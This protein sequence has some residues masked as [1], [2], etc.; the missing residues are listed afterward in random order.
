MK[1]YNISTR[2]LNNY[3]YV[4]AILL[5]AGIA[6]LTG[7]KSEDERSPVITE[8]TDLVLVEGGQARMVIVTADSPNPIVNLSVA[9]LVEH[10]KLATGVEL[11]TTTESDAPAAG[12]KVRLFLGETEAAAELGIDIAAMENDAF[13]FRTVGND[14]YILGRENNREYQPGSMCNGTL[15]GSYELIER[16]LGV[17]WLWPGDLGRHVP[18]VNRVA[19]ASADEVVPPAL[20]GRYYWLGH[21]YNRGGVVSGYYYGKLDE[22]KKSTLPDYRPE[23]RRLAFSADGLKN[24]YLDTLIFLRR[25]RMGFSEPRTLMS[26]THIFQGWWDSYGK[27]HPE[28]FMM[29]EAGERV[30]PTLCVSN[31][32]LA[33]FIVESEKTVW[34]AGGIKNFTLGEVDERVYCHCPECMA[35]DEPLPEG[36]PTEGSNRVISN[37][38]A[39]FAQVIRDLVRERHP[40]TDFRVTPFVYFNYFHKPTVDLDLTG[41]QGVFCPWFSGFDPYYPKPEEEHQRLI[42]TWSGWRQTGMDLCYRP[43]YLLMGYVMPHLS[44][45]Q[46]GEM[47]R[48]A[49]AKGNKSVEFDSLCAHWAVKGPMYYVHMRLTTDPTLEVTDI[50]REYFDSFGPAAA[51]VEAY[52]DYWEAYSANEAKRGGVSWMSPDQAR[53]LYPESSF[54]AA[55]V[56]LNEAQRMATADA[57]PVYGERVKFLDIGLRHAELAAAFIGTLRGGNRAPTHDPAQFA[58]A[59]QALRDL[60]AFRRE[61]EQW[62][63]ADLIAAATTENKGLQIDELFDED[64]VVQAGSV[65]RFEQPWEHWFFRRD[66]ENRGTEGEWFRSDVRASGIQNFDDG[67]GQAFNFDPAQWTRVRVPSRLGNTDIGEYLGYGWYATTFVAPEG[68]AGKPA[69]LYFEGVDEQAWIYINGRYIGEHTVASEGKPVGELWDRPFEINVPAGVIHGKGRNLL[70]VRT[71]NSAGAAG[72]WREVSLGTCKTADK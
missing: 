18:A 42:D 12:E 55:R 59:R 35:W 22:L 37:R 30:G 7:C 56:F 28:W 52:F 21:Y 33:R 57:N 53:L 24:Y 45:W 72:I 48:H 49:A 23:I 47:F 19:I 62:Y 50:R 41:T 29:N 67:G 69:T 3:N 44:T 64:F 38:Y 71:H 17:R 11:Q 54:A 25:H 68:M 58:A 65:V 14:L 6:F 8:S 34:E 31:P 63:F 61:H 20:K 46:T 13:I 66:L 10:V 32:E 27:E 1:N 9:E 26:T 15:Y 60:L 36:W 4:L 5:I 40:G 51:A 2:Q 70:V 16:A 43:N 39:R